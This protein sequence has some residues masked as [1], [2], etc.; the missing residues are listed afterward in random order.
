MAAE[1]KQ[2]STFI[3]EDEGDEESIS[4]DLLPDDLT[5]DTD[6]FG[7]LVSDRPDFPSVEIRKSKGDIWFGRNP[8]L[9]QETRVQ[10]PHVSSWHFKVFVAVAGSA[11]SAVD[12]GD[13]SVGVK[14]TKDAVFVMDASSNGTLVNGKKI[15]KNKT[16]ELHDGDTILLSKINT[17]TTE[18]DALPRYTFQSRPLAAPKTAKKREVEQIEESSNQKGSSQ[19]VPQP[20][21]DGSSPPKK[22]KT[23]D[24]DDLEEQL[25]CV[26]GWQSDR[27]IFEGG[28]LPAFA[29]SSSSLPTILITEILVAEQLHPEK[30]RPQQELDEL[31][32]KNKITSDK[33]RKIRRGDY[34]DDDGDS[35]DSANSIDYDDDDDDSNDDDDGGGYGNVV[36]GM[37]FGFGRPR[38]PYCRFYDPTPTCN[39]A[40]GE[41]LFNKLSDFSFNQM[42]LTVNAVNKNFAELTILQNY[43]QSQNK[44]VGDIWRTGKERMESGQYEL[45]INRGVVTAAAAPAPQPAALSRTS[46]ATGGVNGSGVGGSGVGGSDG[47]GGS[48]N[49]GDNGGAKIGL[50]RQPSGVG[51]GSS[52]ASASAGDGDSAGPPNPPS[53]SG[54]GNPVD[55]AAAPNLHRQGSGTGNNGTAAAPAPLARSGSGN[56]ANPPAGTRITLD[57]YCCRDCVMLVFNELVYLYRRDID[58][59]ELPGTENF[60]C[61]ASDMA[62]P[63]VHQMYATV[64]IVGTVETAGRKHTTYTMH[65]G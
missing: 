19:P 51:S 48:N 22:A 37:G 49:D 26:T 25:M 4:S 62:E 34:Y 65:S 60:P 52:A 56:A 61:V 50:Q 10:D 8:D 28:L 16:S 63:I 18:S 64:R 55:A 12:N 57:S 5:R 54:S 15:G 23:D 21:T 14:D 20:D 42:D 59:N 27:C 7:L 58:P 53:R 17:T 36:Y 44:N 43:L 6:L 32:A 13:G 29:F 30:Q 35:D 2:D 47:G 40:V 11:G 24:H 38:T 41:R 31:N 45:Y 33:P 46:S 1:L 3:I 39:G 9:P